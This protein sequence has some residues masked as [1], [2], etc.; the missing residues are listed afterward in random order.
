MTDKNDVRL[1]DA[2]GVRELC[3]DL[4]DLTVLEIIRVGATAADLET[5]LAWLVNGEAGDGARPPLTG[6]AVRVLEL[7]EAES[8]TAEEP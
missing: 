4:D 1:L 7:L 2:A 5:A 6:A 8:A 3:G